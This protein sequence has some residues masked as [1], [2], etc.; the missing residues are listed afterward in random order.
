MERQT[1]DKKLPL[2]CPIT[3]EKCWQATC[4]WWAKTGCIVKESLDALIYLKDISSWYDENWN[5]SKVVAAT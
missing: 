3:Q 5:L 2:N 1:L 4:A